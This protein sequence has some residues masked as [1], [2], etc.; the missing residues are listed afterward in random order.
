MR[1][2]RC[3][4]A[5]KLFGEKPI[6]SLIDLVNKFGE[7]SAKEEL[8]RLINKA[9]SQGMSGGLFSENWT[10]L[11][12]ASAKVEVK[13]NSKSDYNGY[14]LQVEKGLGLDFPSDPIV[15]RTDDQVRIGEGPIL[16]GREL[17]EGAPES[18]R[19]IQI[20]HRSG[21]FYPDETL[22][23]HQNKIWRDCGSSSVAAY[24]LCPSLHLLYYFFSEWFGRGV[25]TAVLTRLAYMLRRDT[26][27]TTLLTGIPRPYRITGGLLDL[28]TVDVLSRAVDSYFEEGLINAISS[29]SKELGVEPILTLKAGNKYSQLAAYRMAVKHIVE[30][31]PERL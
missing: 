14:L 28:R 17:K 24:A 26:N 29:V 1:D 9:D 6:S 27:L 13:G 30:Q 22:F 20:W 25:E 31:L 12:S 16:D 18:D 4:R 3:A 7:P 23:T 11:A 19:L 10:S 15:V 21:N 8:S 2:S 5:L